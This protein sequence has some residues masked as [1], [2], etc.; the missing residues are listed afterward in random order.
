MFDYLKKAT[1]DLRQA[2]RRV[3]ELETAGEEPLAIVGMACRYPGGVTTPEQLWELVANGTDA[4]SP[5]PADRGWDLD[6][7][8]DPDP[9]HIGTS[10]AREGGFVEGVD[11]FDA[12]FFRI[13]PREAL[14]MDPQ[15]RLLLEVTWELL[16]RAGVDAAGLRG[17]RT[18][19]FTGISHQDY[20]LGLPPSEEVSEGHLMT[21]NAISVVSGRVAYTFGFEGPAVTVDTACSSSLV[22]IHLAGQA[23]RSGDCS[24]AVAGGVTVMATP[25]AFTR[26]SRE[27]GLA[28]DGRCKPFG[29]GADGTGFSDGVGVL[30]LE[31]LSD[32]R[33]RGHQVLAIVRGTAVNQDGASNGLTAPNGPS[34]QR[35][36]RQALANARLQP[37]DVDAVEAH[38]TGTTLGDPIE[39]QALLATYGQGRE[40]PLYL[41]SLKSNIGHTQAAAGVGGVIKM[42]QAMRNG[43]LPRT[44]HADEPTPEVDWA[45]GAVSLLTEAR[46]WENGTRPR[47]AG[48]SS[49]GISGTNAHL[50]LEQPPEE[51]PTGPDAE[52]APDRPS[53]A[54]PWLLSARSTAAL[55]EQAARLAAHTLAHPEL[56]LTDLAFS[57]ATT[58]TALDHRATVVAADR[59]ALLAGLTALADPGHPGPAAPCEAVP[60]VAWV[61]SGQGSQRPG[62]GRELYARFPVFADALDEACG[63][64]DRWVGR[65]VRDAM[66]ADAENPANGAELADTGLAQPV[67]FAFQV[68]L[69]RLWRSWGLSPDVVA[70]HSVGEFAAAHV[71]G[72][73]SLPDAARV[74]AERG[75]LMAELAPGGGMTAVTA[76]EADSTADLPAGV[77]VAA[78]N[79]PTATVLAGPL[80]LLET[81]AERLRARGVRT[82]ALRVSHAFHSTLVEPMLAEFGAVLAD[83]TW[84]RPEVTF[85]STLTGTP[86]SDELCDAAYWTRHARETVRFADALGALRD[87]GVTALLELGPDGT[88][89]A[90]AGDALG[91]AIPAQRK[92][93]GQEEALL[94]A[95]TGLWEHGA[96][97]DWP[98]VF[99]GTGAHRTALP[100]YPFQRERYWLDPVS[101]LPGRPGLL[102]L[103]APEHPLLGAAVALADGDLVLFTARLS[104]RTH[105]WLADHA[106]QGTVLL[107]GTAF[108]ELALHAGDRAGC[109]RLDELTLVTPLALSATE[110]VHLQVVVAAPDA[111]GRRVTTVHSRPEDAADDVPWTLNATGFLTAASASVPPGDLAVWPP[112]GATPLPVADFY[113]RLGAAGYHYGPAFQ[114]LRAA[115]TRDGETFAE[116]ALPAER[117]QEAAA[118]G[119]HP[120]LLDAALHATA[121]DTTENA[122]LLPFAWTGVTLH[123]TGAAALRVRVTPTGPEAAQIL[124][125][126]PT[127]TPVATID[128]LTTR[129]LDA[130]DL[131]GGRTAQGDALFRVEWTATPMGT[132]GAGEFPGA[133]PDAVEGAAGA[134]A[135]LVDTGSDAIGLDAVADRYPGLPELAAAQPLPDVVHVSFPAGSEL[136]ASAAHGTAQRALRLVREWLAEE[137]LSSARLVLVT[138]GCDD[139]VN[140]VV[141]GLVRAAQSEHPGRFVLLDVDEEP[142]ADVLNAVAVSVEPQLRL[143]QGTLE[144]PRLARVAAPAQAPVAWSSEGTVLITGGTGGLGGLVARHLVAEHGVRHLV[145]AGRRGPDAPGARE[146]RAELGALGAH[147][148]LAACDAADRDALGALLAGISERHPLTAVVHTAGVLAD[149]VVEALTP[150]RLDAVL[151]PKVDAA[152]HLH[153]LTRD[154]DL[155]AFVLFSSASGLLGGPGQ[156]NYAAAN[157]FLDALARHRTAAGLPGVSLA[158]GAWDAGAGMTGTL[159]AL[160]TRRMTRGGILPLAPELG[161]ALFDTALALGVPDPA[162]VR[163]DL[164]ALRTSA[165]PVPALL[166]RLVRARRR[167]AENPPG[168][169]AA[170]LA[171]QLAALPEAERATRLTALVRAQ[172]A[173][174]LGYA[175]PGAIGDG[176]AFKDLGFD[177]L[178]AVELRNALYAR[179][180]LRLPATL[181]FDHPTPG[182]LAAHLGEE[183]L[184]AGAPA[185]PV[186]A[187]ASAT[188]D[189]PIAIV[190]MGCRFPGGVVSADGLWDLVAG[191]VD[192][193]S[194]FPADRGWDLES[195]YDPDPDRLGTSYTRSGGFLDDVSGFDAEFFGMSPREAM[196]TDPQQRLLLETTWE[197]FERAGLNPASLR[198]SSTGVFL[199]VMY[200]DYASRLQD[201]FQ[202]HISSGS[203]A[204]VAS[205]RISYTFGLEGPAMTVD[206]ACSSSLVAIH[207]AAQALRQGECGMALAGGVTVMSTP[208]TFVEFS[209]QRG[210]SADGRCKAFGAGADGTGWSEGVGVL[211]L[212][213]LSDAVRNGHEV[214][215]VVR[216]SAVNQDGASNGLTAPNGPAQQ[217]VIRQALANARL[218]PSDVDAVEAHGT[219][220][221]LGDPIEAQA[222]L[223]AYGQDRERPL[224]LGSLKS[225]IGHTQAAAGVGGVIKMVQAIRHGLLPRTL[226]AERPNPHIDWSTG[227][228]EL[229]AEPRPWP[230]TGH[231]RR[232]AVSAFGVSGTNAHVVVE[233]PPGQRGVTPSEPGAAAP[234]QSGGAAPGAPVTVPW[235]L[236]ARTPDALRDQARRLM[237]LLD[238]DGEA[239]QGGPAGLSPVDRHLPGQGSADPLLDVVGIGHAL[240]TTRAVFSHRAVLVG[241]ERDEFR[242]ALDALVT[243]TVSAA[244]IRG[245][246]RERGKAA[247]VFPGQGSQ[248]TGM[249]VELLDSAPVFAQR[250]RECEEALAPYVDWS[251]AQVLGDERALG[252]VD[253]VQPVLWAVMVSLAALWRS[254]GVEPAAV[255]GHSQGEIAAACVA[256]A[257]SLADGAKVVALRSRLIRAEL[258]GNGG[259]LSVQLPLEETESRLTPWRDRLSVAAVNSPATVVVAG[260]A[261]ALDALAA[262]CEADGVR[263]RRVP[264]DYASHSAHVDSL[265]DQLLADLAD[266]APRSATLPFYSAVTGAPFDTTALTADYWYRNLR[267]TVRFDAATRAAAEQGHTHFVEVSPHAVLTVATQQTLEAAGADAV[268]TGTLRR[269][270]GGPARMLTSLAEA[271]VG[272]VSPDWG[273][274]FAGLA[275]HP[276]APAALPTYAFQHERYWPPAV[277]G[278]RADVAS[279]G[280]RSTAHPLLGAAVPLVGDDL[281]LVGRLSLATHPWL[282]DHAV[283]GTVLLPGTA[284][285]ELALHA[286][287][288]VDCAR[289]SE[290]TLET[291]LVLDPDTALQIQVTVRAPDPAGHRALT[292]NSRAAQADPDTPWTLHATATLAQTATV[293]FAVDLAVWPPTGATRLA[294]DG[295]YDDLAAT[296]LGYGPAFRGVREVWRRDGDVFAEVR[297]GEGE[298]EDAERFGV[299]PALLDAALHPYLFTR[300]DDG[301]SLPFAWTGVSLHAHGA[302]ALRVRLAADG[303][304]EAADETGAPVLTA[305]SLLTR[306]LPGTPLTGVRRDGLF[307]IAWQPCPAAG[308]APSGVAVL[309]PDG[310]GLADELG[311]PAHA[312]LAALTGAGPVP[313]VVLAPVTGAPD[314]DGDAVLAAVT[315]AL[316]LV[317]GW[318]GDARCAGSRLVV[319]TRGA[320]A[321]DATEDPHDLVAAAVRGLLRSAQSEHPDRITLADLDDPATSL[322]ALLAHTGTGEPELAVRAGTVRTAR[323]LRATAPAPAPAPTSTPAPAWSA[324]GTVL[325]TGG[326][327]L[328]GGL[329]A[330]HLVV[331]HGVRHLVLASRRGLDAPGAGELVEE[332]GV[333]GAEVTVVACDVGDRGAL[334][335]LIDEWPPS[336]VVHA[337][338]VLDDGVVGSLTADRL[339]AVLRPKVDAALNLHE[340]TRGLDL[341][342][343]VLFSS[344]AAAFGAPGQANYAAANACVDA[345]AAHRRALGLPGLAVGWGLWEEAGGMTGHLGADDVARHRATGALPL[346]SADGLRLFD[347][348]VEGADAHVVAVPLDLAAL[349]AAPE[350]PAL[351]RALV[352]NVARPAARSADVGP[353]YARRLAVL[354]GPE[355]EHAL[356]D[357]VRTHVAAVLGHAGPEAVDETSAFGDLGFD[358][359]TAVGLRNQLTAATGLQLPAT[360]VFDH[361]TPTA[362][363][364]HLRS[365]LVSEPVTGAGSSVAVPSA[366]SRSDD[367]P[368]VVIGMACRYPGGV[369]SPEDLWR[370]VATGTD[371]IAAMPTDRGWDIEGLYDPEHRRPGT[372]STREGGFLY[373]AAEF[374]AAFFGISP[375]EAL[376]T[377]P[378][379]RLLL[380]TAWHAFEDAGIDPA[381][382]RGSRTGVFA[383]VMYHDYGSGLPS[384][385]DDVEGYLG[386]GTSGSVASGRVSY[387]L[388]LEG[389]AITVDTACSSSL[390]TLH[391]AAQALRQGECTM[392][393]AGGVTVMATPG[394]FVEFSR[395]RGL[396]PDG[397]CKAFG[398][399]A[400]GT[401]WGEGVGMLLLER[402]SDARRNGHEVLAIVRGTAVNQDGASNGLSAPNG[403]AQQRVI[404]QALANARLEPADV[405][406]VEAHGTGTT[407]GDPIEAQALLAAYG[408]ERERPLYLGSLKSNIGHT[409][410]AAGVAGVIKMVQAMRNGTLPPT[411]HA[412]EPSPHVD[413]S[414][415]DVRL[416]TRALPWPETGRPRRAGVSSF[417]VSGTNAH[418][419][420]EHA[421]EQAS[422]ARPV[423]EGGPVPWVLSARSDRSLEEQARA[424][425]A[426][427]D[428]HP[429]VTPADLGLSLATTRSALPHRAVVLGT[430]AAGP[431][432]TLLAL[433][434][435]DLPAQLVRGVAD[436]RGRT[437]FVFPGQGSQWTG[438]A[439]ELL[440]SAP[441]F[442]QRMRECE[443]ALAPYVDWSLAHVLHDAEMLE[444]VDVVQPA[445]WAV[446]VSLAALWR[447]Y[448]V[449][450]AAVLGHSQGEIAAACVAGALSL[451][452]GAKVVA[453]RSQLIRAELAGKGGM[454]SVE[455]SAQ[456][457]E[458]RLIPWSERLSVAAVNGPRSTVFAGDPD[459]LDEIRVAV[460]A[461]GR[462]VRTIPVDYASHTFHVE[463]LEARL[464]GELAGITP[465]AA[466]IPFFSTVTVDWQDGA[467]LDPAYWYRNLRRQVRFEQS[468]RALAA[469]GFGFFVETSSHPVLTHG[470][471][472]T[473][474]NLTTGAVALGTLRRGHGT[475]G[476]FWRSLAEAYVRGLDCDWAPAF[477]GGRRVGLPL[478]AFDRK[479]YWLASGPHRASTIGPAPWR[480]RVTW[481]PVT[482][483]DLNGG[484]DEGSWIVVRSS[485]SDGHDWTRHLLGPD[486]IPVVVDPAAV[487]RAEFARLLDAATPASE[488]LSGVLCLLADDQR[489]HPDQPTV[490]VGTA[491]TLALAQALGDLDLEAPLWLVTRGAVAVRPGERPEPGQAQVCGLGRSL[492]HEHPER[493]GGLLDLPRDL[494]A[495]ALHRLT[496]L[497]RRTDGEDELAVRPSGVYARR[498][499][500]DD[501]RAAVPAEAWRPTGTVLVTGGTGALGGHVARWLARN[502]A[503]HVVLTGRRGLDAPGAAELRAE[504]VVLG[505][506][507]TVAACDAADRDALARLIA[508]HPPTAVIHTAGVLDDGVLDQLDTGRLATVFAPKT[509]AATHLHELTRDLPLTAFVLFSSAAGVLGSA[510][511]ANYAAA[512][513]HVDALAE[514]R[515]ADGLPATSVA[516]GA[517]A[518][519]GLAMDAGVV[520]QRLRHSGVS[521]MRPEP[522]VR[523]LQGALDAGDT[524]LLVIDVDWQRFAAAGTVAPPWLRALVTPEPV[525]GAGEPAADDR[526]GALRRRLAEQSPGDRTRT[527][528]TLVRGQAAAV[529]GHDG[530]DAVPGDRAFRDLGFDSL[531][532][533]ELRN[534]LTAVT[535]LKLP[536]TLVFDHPSATALATH[537]A[538]Q[539]TGGTPALGLPAV[540]PAVADEPIAIV[541]MSCRFPGGVR[542]PQELW[543]LLAA[544]R[545]AVGEF[546]TDRGW[547]LDALYHP[548]PE[549]L[550]TTYTRHGAFLHDAAE[551]D[552]ALFG[553]SPREALAMDPQQRLLLE[554][555]WEAFERAGIDPTALKGTATGVFVGTNGQDYVSGL[556]RVPDG[557]EGYLLAG[558][559]ASVVSGRL[560][561]TFGLEGPAV[562]VDTACSSSLVALHLA[563][564][565]LRQ[566]ECA[567]AVAGGASV[568]STPASFVEF[569]RQRGLAADGRCKPFAAAADGT[570]WGE[571]V[572]LLLLE[573]LSDAERNGHEVLAIVRGSAVNQDGASNGLTAPN[574]P[575]QQRVIQQALANARLEPSDV[576]AVEAHGTGTTLGDPIEAQALLATYGRARQHP[577]LLGSVKSNLGHTQAAAGVAGVIKAVEAMRHGILPGSLHIDEP[578]PHVDWSAGA[579]TLATENTPWPETGRPRRTGVSSFGVSGTNAHVVLEHSPSATTCADTG[580]DEFSPTAEQPAHPLPF[581]LSARTEAALRAQAGRLLDR[582]GAEDA[583]ALPDTAYSLVTSR[584][585][586]EHRAAL[587][588]ADRAGLRAALTALT[589]GRTPPGGATGVVR[590]TPEVAWVF[591]GQG[592]QRP[593]MGRELYERYPAFAEA[594]DEVCAETDRWL[595]RPLRETMFDRSDDGSALRNTALAQPALFAF[596]VAL[597]RLLASWGLRP[598]AVAGHSVG[599]FAAACVAGVLS[600]PDAAR[601]VTARGRLMAALPPGG[602]MTAVEADEATAAAELPDGV[603]VAAVNGPFATV[604]S[605][606]LDALAAL[607]E[608]FRAAG[609]RT[610]PLRVSHAFHS[611]LMEPAL[612]EF[613]E[614][615]ADVEWQRPEVRFVSTLTGGPVTDELCDP[616]YWTRHAREAVRFA[617]AVDALGESGVT[618][619]LELGPDGTLTGMAGDALPV[620]LPTQRKDR[621]EEPAVLSAVSGLWA[622][623]IAPDWPALLDGTG[624]RHVALPTYPFQRERYWIR[625]AA[626][627]VGGM[628]AAGLT[629]ADHPLLGA[630][631]QLAGTDGALFTGSLSLRTHPWLADHAVSGVAV[632]PGTAYVELAV[633]A[634]DQVGCGRVDELTLEAPL[635]LPER[636]SVQL[637][638]AVGAPDATGR[639][640]LDLHAR[641][642]DPA[643]EGEWTRHATGVLAADA[644]AES[645]DLTA[646][647]P[648]NAV[649]VPVDDLYERIAGTSFGYGPAF[650]GLRAAWLLDDTVFAE[651]ALPESHRADAERFGLH[652][653]LLDAALHTLALRPRPADL[654]EAYQDRMPFSWSGVTL[655]ATG[656]DALRVRL[657]GTGPDLV[658]LAVADGA[659]RPVAAV[660]AL[661]L[662][663]VGTDLAAGAG[664]ART[665]LFTLDWTEVPEV[666][667]A[668]VSWAVVDDAVAG[669]GEIPWPAGA[670]SGAVAGAGSGAVV[671]ACRSASGPHDAVHRALACVQSWLAQ[672]ASPQRPLVFVTEDAAGPGARDLTYAPVWGLVRSAQSEHPGRFLLL[673]LDRAPDAAALDQYLPLALATGEPQL[674]LRD[675]TLLAPRVAAT[676]TGDTL[677][678][679]GG[680]DAWRLDIVDRGTVE[681]LALVPDPRGAAPLAATEIRVAM[682]AAGMNFRDVL[683]TLGAYPGDAVIGI[684]GAG[685]VVETGDEVTGIA[686]GDR[687]MGLFSGAFGP[688][689][690]TD[691]RMVAPIPHGWSFA[692][693]ASV[694]V[695]FLTASY[696]LRDLAQLQPG[697]PVLIHAAAGGVGMAAVQLAHGLGA[698]VFA[699]AS[700]AKWDTLRALGIPDDRIAS[701]R[702]LEFEERFRTATDG[703]GLGVVLNSLAGDYVD[704]SLRT[705]RPG[706]RFLEMGKAD[707]RSADAV[708]AELPDVNYAAFDL[709][710]AGPDRIQQLFREVLALFAD[711]TLTPLPLATW[712]VRRAKD[713]FRTMSQ[714]RHTG[715]IVLT[716]PTPL[717]PA[718][719]VLVTGA[720]GALGGAVARH[721][722]ERHGVQRLLLLGRRG[723]DTP[724]ARRLLADLAALGA[725]A[726]F[727][728]C[729]TG[730]RDAL[731]AVLADVP[732][733]HPLTAV[734]HCAGV[735][736]D[737]VIEALTPERVDRVLRAKVDAARNL[738]DLTTGADLAA[739]LLF[740]SAAGIFGSPGQANYAAGNAYVDALALHRRAAGH[741]AHSLAWGP[742]T[743]DDGMT[744]TLADADRARVGRGGMET[745]STAEGLALFDAARTAEPALLLP[746]RLGMANLREQARTGALAPLLRGLVTTPVR[747]VADSA[748]TPADGDGLAV[749]LAGLSGP[750]QEELL[751]ELVRGE[752]SVVLGHGSPDAVEADRG[753][754]DLG[755]D[756]LTALEF[757][758]RLGAVAGLRLTATLIFDHPTPLALARHLRHQLLPDPAP[759]QEPVADPAPDPGAPTGGEID[760]ID[761]IDGMALDHLVQLALEGD[762]R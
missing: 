264:V 112:E 252:R 411:L 416:L 683:G 77:T 675:G 296:G 193:I 82:R 407:L 617:D 529:L 292:I 605:G 139:P 525:A 632:L 623:G 188:T 413:W 715:K 409:Q 466:D 147:V 691:H 365:L 528:L 210:L 475:L 17:S 185:A 216:G 375:R 137:R 370:L 304:I 536:A 256:G 500:R 577:L 55:R 612:T 29:A 192:A 494:D 671:V 32:A 34:Q 514:Q 114:G 23:L 105:P 609:V 20:A 480:H 440:A 700:P 432:T 64:L 479:R 695:A 138:H 58:R 516:W 376:G 202:G 369:R 646:W 143:R 223:A 425:A 157:A 314:A 62:M 233:G 162:P 638:L 281:V 316:A 174:V 57:L 422:S 98:A 694:P 540:A 592:S 38:G 106:V 294:T 445:L 189:E 127:G 199:G 607:A 501:D 40:R 42:V 274:V 201:T 740:S 317:Q 599:E 384:V 651:I 97:P 86:V 95:L 379:Q 732:A 412:E 268:V 392:A 60:R 450:P 558:N 66:F 261:D 367:D 652:P 226:H 78:V 424:L 519:G 101:A 573:R 245:T 196:A 172:V 554:T 363:A 583:P 547:D 608:R 760:E 291:P 603:A 117:Q 28:P 359:L 258:A 522:A 478:Y 463:P 739:F 713:A 250:M 228:V 457:A 476:R 598:D 257:L 566:G 506:E 597:A 395:Q 505:A 615:L 343:F 534:R 126:D 260:D 546:P 427:A 338:G 198:G 653:A 468:V 150:E 155:S 352:R 408:Q 701:S 423:G 418:A 560:A 611:P 372:F 360:L 92:D 561:Y 429:E 441:V 549:H 219:G 690:V 368:V 355:R 410:A 733:R 538:T 364:A 481:H 496:G 81:A 13:S 271:H 711:G 719:T 386:G 371:A 21:G 104:P 755:F 14:A 61:F 299:H 53:T 107:P 548:D 181:V 178:T 266:I 175:D 340:L 293:P 35:V 629:D 69:A 45:A 366:G 648:P 545:D 75:R 108:V 22:A 128:T 489:P 273:T 183:L 230:D 753:F 619:L 286:A 762:A 727:T 650:Q 200:N 300:Q 678:I 309:G 421:P 730:D 461:C 681:G 2:R 96:A 103:T 297:L 490:P 541:A 152:L 746:V 587:V 531:T 749:R 341:S 578:T 190:A 63:E 65:S 736:D 110:A 708:A 488:P 593:G 345:L 326:T 523:A 669:A 636:G 584:A 115:W 72:V 498:L 486:V 444:R 287:D 513:A 621:G 403:P 74:V 524:T 428:A 689:A 154:L 319:V 716:V 562:T 331:E 12:P 751:L 135:V 337:A 591:S 530:P 613:A 649:P 330:R 640:S 581:A 492:A 222:L 168:T 571:G 576:D 327:G 214:L 339:G 600:V 725:E 645:F 729:D 149:G 356:L 248:W 164:T 666:T 662:R 618:V 220:T 9:D 696:G 699:T 745:L 614:V 419:I 213:R 246:A 391:L 735:L 76:S 237:A 655:Y 710:D 151:R 373:D 3:R 647:P 334:A 658:S 144:I 644:P 141:W 381:T 580:V 579:V 203:A 758:N 633:R 620:V 744:S 221:T 641:P 377:D 455:L 487:D 249:A 741:P 218:E 318:L 109:P 626:A 485:A 84:R 254:Y 686:P 596:Q 232:A 277:T 602:G 553:I 630:A 664:G 661:R 551:F 754:L 397:R 388:G 30:L 451:A 47:R 324:D 36:I 557:A 283:R 464:L 132:S 241:R 556:T 239:G 635:L 315:E 704:A 305:D 742:W 550:G 180:G 570:G 702:T 672:E 616:A 100:T 393:L 235:V 462:R 335:R 51:A 622:H 436:I 707:L 322:P 676:A 234:V 328:L 347:A 533:V 459:A 33:R 43:T 68:A 698:E 668:E 306:P 255:I 5:F 125:T 195:L 420:L 439:V 349:R 567:L 211:L 452:D 336:A 217:R 470:I 504:L 685:V 270:D 302:R 728:A 568:M 182:A 404:R 160:D 171:A 659:G 688:L 25:N 259:M 738:H 130:G 692:T 535:G 434:Q 85:V 438:M 585:A 559:A 56:A 726:T 682:R 572:G 543:E 544:G 161:L 757:R 383:G 454:L 71:A 518:G 207:L 113:E 532:A 380:E 267:E 116:V 752:A 474:E 495:P 447:S 737:G 346:S 433:A 227:A 348:A 165:E 401:G 465:R 606:P 357:L 667:P 458:A 27:R 555:A 262:A 242:R 140:A 225:N 111:S 6:A 426:H 526:A 136:S 565:S 631:V 240:A 469:Q 146:L 122:R 582:L 362:L 323:L 497:L 332:L 159:D 642:W 303:R 243:D 398:A 654:D 542:T 564:Q 206:T 520:E 399:G 50:I 537:L 275:P 247:F 244:L 385:P 453:L 718:G 224:Y 634:G 208:T 4:V 446:M 588:A 680:T 307:T 90:L 448:G 437:V 205:G 177:S 720:A 11:G 99:T 94:G 89:S 430:E 131:T 460:E 396:A 91:T 129:P 10:Y 639:R 703:E 186:T 289:I 59:D 484:A 313:E 467:G 670:V 552:A 191:G 431:R 575:A 236:S 443:E 449:E 79:G 706:G 212:E 517:W 41:G 722:A 288:H 123:A 310:L 508:A 163:L 320:V 229:L 712:D 442:A 70:G 394:T 7:L 673:D 67:L 280:L 49:F 503:A 279:V 417:G 493:W 19:V 238:G 521:P 298:F 512:N 400:D 724:Q 1:T 169:P 723:A 637:Q 329:V 269:G 184:G 499:V 231:P 714:A 354:S 660:D 721:L 472:E 435:G 301:I 39:A 333:L 748:P 179:T 87:L 677:P 717:D 509:A 344:A 119:L 44:L 473:A 743:P 120:A 594:L 321:V 705:L 511:Q 311:V 170:G 601:L 750:A 477:P 415:G 402:L 387:T 709:M 83:V 295:L 378:Q 37:S 209:R 684:E 693:A 405:D 657:D 747:R 507:V 665:P 759:D 502:G 167:S 133:T 48:V 26:F 643:Q 173:E 515:R 679:P 353:A 31:R 761:E 382:V 374:D 52:P 121:V 15:Q 18:G 604:L 215:A 361:P 263:A 8:Y 586:L 627:P 102:G 166:G 156:A 491:A 483:S 471:Q 253:V 134:W 148:T 93:R 574:G 731:A 674:A 282:A 80:D 563:A 308:Q 589:E 54:L 204:S 276:A 194:G 145:L 118:F 187:A 697:E 624:A 734:V 527:L 176:R 46:T 158:W 625:G 197:V 153:E 350:V 482:D 406:A 610:R 285:V 510:G 687:V 24:L 88:L 656:A 595:E 390:V 456:E 351:L 312:G 539:L 284:F 342:A 251:L 265:R 73:L 663:P 278:D 325:I 756:S 290:L 628:S 358:S 389:P 16:E 142:S 590:G 414:A 272:G 124:T 569:S